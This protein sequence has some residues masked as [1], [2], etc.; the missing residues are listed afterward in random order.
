MKANAFCSLFK[1]GFAWITMCFLQI[2]TY[3]RAQDANKA[4]VVLTR[5]EIKKE[6]EE[7]I[8]EVLRM[9]VEDAIATK[10]NIMAE[11][12]H[13]EEN[14]LI[15]WTIERWNSQ[16]DLQKMK[17]RNKNNLCERPVTAFCV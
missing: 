8:R 12:Y 17:Q 5:Y 7:K 15:L 14:L 13:E 2:S 4:V 3:A 11:A 1:N 16:N 6:Y 9:Y 10:S